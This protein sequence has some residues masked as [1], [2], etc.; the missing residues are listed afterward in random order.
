[1]SEVREEKLSHLARLSLHASAVEASSS[2]LPAAAAAAV[3]VV[4]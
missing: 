4:A 3:V 1:M 2:V